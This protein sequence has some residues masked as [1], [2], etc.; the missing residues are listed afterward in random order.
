MENLTD[1]FVE[2]IYSKCNV[3]VSN[4]VIHQVKR[5]IIDYFS[6]LYAG[7][8]LLGSIALNLIE[9]YPNISDGSS[10]IGY[11]IK[12]SP[13]AAAFLNGFISHFAELDDGVNSGIV[14]PG[15]PV[16]S[17]LF[18][19][20]QERK[21]SGTNLIKGINAGY[22]TTI[23]LANAVQPGH[24]K[25]GYHATGTIGAA[26][27]AVALC[28]MTGTEKKILK[29]AL[30]AALISS[31]GTLKALEDSSQLKPFNVGNA[32]R[33]GLNAFLMAEAGIEGPDDVLGGSKG[34]LSIM[35]DKCDLEKLFPV[36]KD[37]AIF[38]IYIKPYAACRYCHPAIEASIELSCTHE[39]D[40]K[41]IKEIHVSTY[42][43]AVK[44]HDHTIIPNTSSAK[45]SIPFSVATALV[46]RMGGIDAF[47]EKNVSNEVINQLTKKVIVTADTKFTDSFPDKSIA[48]V[49]VVMNN[50]EKF[51]KQ[52]M[53]PKG[54]PENPL[55]DV[56][57]MQKVTELGSVGGFSEEQIKK[58]AEIVLNLDH[59]VSALYKSLELN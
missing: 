8:G 19:I 28:I 44:S 41:Q 55:T 54:E 9:K 22:E 51:S 1:K 24:K 23:R 40:P 25:R 13:D 57:L 3:E 33:T 21:I 58:I 5:C 43:L 59:N 48:L 30:S 29:N 38:D 52:V 11:G 35:T 42:E 10:V 39:I 17:A 16:L 7:K 4:E 20:A 37:L 12:K 6:V 15:T 34:F 50:S 31:G 32:A 26:G 45:M 47:S 27:A 53:Y 46:N 18:A 56:E 49:S 14:H 2:Y 36:D